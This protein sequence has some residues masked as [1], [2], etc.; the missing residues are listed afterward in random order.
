MRRT[1]LAK[2][3]LDFAVLDQFDWEAAN[4]E[5][6]IDAE[7]GERREVA[8]GPI[9]ATLYIYTLRGEEDHAISLRRAERKERRRYVEK[10]RASH[11]G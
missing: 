8:T 2:H 6:D 11:R 4:I 3:G 10:I 9:G 5:E 1:N 7:Y